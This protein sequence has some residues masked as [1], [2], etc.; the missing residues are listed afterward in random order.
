MDIKESIFR[1]KLFVVTI[2]EYVYII[3]AANKPMAIEI[4]EKEGKGKYTNCHQLYSD[5]PE[6]VVYTC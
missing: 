5:G 1:K 3:R 2:G 4:A 6:T